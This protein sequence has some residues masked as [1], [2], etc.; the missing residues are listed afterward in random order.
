[1]VLEAYDLFLVG[2]LCPA[3]IQQSVHTPKLDLELLFLFVN[4]FAL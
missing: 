3:N 2:S 1:M 4:T